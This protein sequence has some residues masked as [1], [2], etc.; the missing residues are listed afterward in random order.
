MRPALLFVALLPAASGLGCRADPGAAAAGSQTSPAPAPVRR[1]V[2]V[3]TRGGAAFPVAVEIA[4]T[5]ESR[6]RGLMYR[7]TL[8]ADEGMLFVFAVEKEQTFWMHNTLLPL[9]MVFL[10]S[11][12]TVV[13][14]VADA[15]P[16]TDRPRSVGRPSRHVL[17]LN[18]GWCALHG[19]AVG[20]RVELSD[21]LL[22]NER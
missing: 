2:V 5:D 15:Q 10:A 22:K 16:Q 20:D 17:E 8:G 13:G 4:D 9:D 11:D 12:G 14:I 18:G 7:R 6:A 21:A 19:V 1:R 3:A